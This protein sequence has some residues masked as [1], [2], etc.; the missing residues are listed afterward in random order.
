MTGLQGFN[1]K[2]YYKSLTH[3][4][5]PVEFIDSI[6]CI[7]SN[8]YKGGNNHEPHKGKEMCDIFNI[9]YMLGN[10]DG[11]GQGLGDGACRCNNNSYTKANGYASG[12]G[13]G[14][15]YGNIN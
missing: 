15:G 12:D 11:D 10:G 1:L 7:L 6:D 3:N 14:Y 13:C 8:P 2:V 5:T 4:H 9:G